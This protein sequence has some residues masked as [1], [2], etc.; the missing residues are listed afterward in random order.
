M[1]FNGF[2]VGYDM[3]IGEDF[4]DVGAAPRRGGRRTRA[5][6]RSRP[7]V[8]QQ[9]AGI[10]PVAAKEMPLGLGSCLF[11][12]AQPL[13]SQTLSVQ[14]QVPFRGRRLVIDIARTGTTST[15]LVTVTAFAVGIKDQRGGFGVLGAGV[16]APNA[17]NIV[18]MMDPAGPGVTITLTITISAI[19]TTTDRVDV[20]ATIIGEGYS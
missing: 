5:I 1:T 15:G 20:N 17:T 7:P 19:P 18:L 16:F 4:D 11:A 14:P 10:S 6:A 13:P 3:D 2:D 8:V 9:I 12:V